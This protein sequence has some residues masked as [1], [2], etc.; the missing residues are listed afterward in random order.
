MLLR[1]P[2]PPACIGPGPIPGPAIPTSLGCAG[3]ALSGQGPGGLPWTPAAGPA[4]PVPRRHR[5]GDPDPCRRGP[6]TCVIC[7]GDGRTPQPD[8]GP[9]PQSPGPGP[10]SPGP[11]PHGTL[12]NT[13]TMSLGPAPRVARARRRHAKCIHRAAFFVPGSSRRSRAQRMRS[14]ATRGPLVSRRRRRQGTNRAALLRASA[15]ES[16]P[17]RPG[18]GAR[19]LRAV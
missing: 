8:T 19:G 9:G 6:C 14:G 12:M 3:W 2:S 16:R 17:T 11:G 18:P 1:P 5:G 15:A 4:S 10:Q 7:G 13:D